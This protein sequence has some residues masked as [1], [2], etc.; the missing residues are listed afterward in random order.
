[1]LS[2]VG[3]EIKLVHR[4]DPL[5]DG[6]N[7]SK[8]AP[9]LHGLLMGWRKEDHRSNR[10]LPVQ[11]DVPELICDEAQS[12]LATEKDKGVWDWALIA[13]YYLLR[14]GEYSTKSTRNHTK[15]TKQYKMEDVTLFKKDKHGNIQKI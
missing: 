7:T 8:F 6:N 4:H 13:F 3:E 9:W 12:K 1:M 10:M 5:K 2:A 14:I 15:Q 11:V